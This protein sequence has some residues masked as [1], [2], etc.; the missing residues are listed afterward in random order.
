MRDNSSPPIRP[1]Q[2]SR[3][4]KCP[5]VCVFIDVET[6]S[7]RGVSCAQTIETYRLSHAIKVHREHGRWCRRE[8]V[9]FTSGR[10]M[11]DWVHN[12]ERYKRPVWVFAHN[13][14]FDLTISGFFDLVLAGRYS[15]RDL[16]PRMD[17]AV[18]HDGRKRKPWRGSVVLTD[19]PTIL[20]LRSTRG[21]LRLVDTCNYYYGPLSD[22]G[23]SVGLP[24]LP[25]PD[26][27]SPDTEWRERCERDCE[28]LERAVC[29]WIDRWAGLECGSWAYTAAGLGYRGWRSTLSKTK[30][31]PNHE[32]AQ[33][34]LA[35]A[36][37]YSGQT[38]VYYCGSVW[39][40]D[41]DMDSLGF[42]PNKM[43]GPNIAGP[44]Y[45]LDVHSLYPA[46]MASRPYPCKFLG[47]ERKVSLDAMTARA[48]FHLPIAR[49]MIR[50]ESDTYPVRRN[51][52]Y[53]HAVGRYT[54]CLCG[55]ELAGAI[56]RGH[57][58]SVE[59][60]A[61]YQPADLFS[62]FVKR[63]IGIR[64]E[65]AD[66]GD[67]AGEMLAKL[68]LNSLSGKFAQYKTSWVDAPDIAPIA[69]F[70]EWE[71]YHAQTKRII[72]YRAFGG[73]TQ[74]YDGRAES[75]QSMPAISAHIT[76]NGRERMR[77]L[78]SL[79]PS[80][81]VLYMDTDSLMVLQPAYDALCMAG[82]VREREMG[83]L[84][85]KDVWPWME[86]RG[87]KYYATPSGVTCPGLKKD[88]RIE[89]PGIYRQDRFERLA[90]ILADYQRPEVIVEDMRLHIVGS[91]MH[92]S[93]GRNG[94]TTAPVLRAEA[95]PF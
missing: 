74:R 48:K 36:A 53:M 80:N 47:I 28:I 56:R 30:V 85:L 93:T 63:W 9:S 15:A 90:S 23:E 88:A 44:V 72:R 43:T 79:C 58:E 94:W 51:G 64:H 24:Q 26:R 34:E 22:M 62:A 65:S 73:C 25:A 19:P 38:E 59:S 57:V 35:R 31:I 82:E 45:H 71:V 39:P 1:I 4:N 42:R 76:A 89:H 78:R 92:R 18:S 27:D 17:M 50:S 87:F 86:I 77:Y 84:R 21:S 20:V 2:P 83:Y 3:G 10:D 95:P 5:S 55:D 52:Q 37:Y 75:K 67:H 16:W 70:G 66:K 29:G 7:G 69:P 60:V 8:S 41:A 46:V 14:G 6:I 68:L 54:T 81:T 61:W 33:I 40:A 13:L 12:M 91:T 49:V 11:W 32:P